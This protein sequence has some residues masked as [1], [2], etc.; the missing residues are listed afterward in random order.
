MMTTALLNILEEL[1]AS[2][3]QGIFFTTQVVEISLPLCPP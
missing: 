2:T 3:F 1:A